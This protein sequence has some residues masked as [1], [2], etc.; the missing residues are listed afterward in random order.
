MI[1]PN[2]DHSYHS[3]L[4]EGLLEH[5]FVGEVMRCLWQR[6][7]RDF[8]VLRPITDAAGYDIVLT[9]NGKMRHVQLKSSSRDAKTARQNINTAL[10]KHH[11]SCIVWI[12]FD[13]KSL[14]M[15]PYHWFGGT[16][17][18]PLPDLGDTV[19]RHTKGD[20][21]GTKK[22]RPA[23]RVLPKGR[24]ESGLNLQDIVDRLFGSAKS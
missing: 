10:A 18:E 14:E 16:P 9:A 13:S 8:E 7:I 24:F 11:S 3:S 15:G 6:G 1:N 20:A 23:I 21:T 22:E 19:G 2:A 4:R 17:D 12:R 5:L